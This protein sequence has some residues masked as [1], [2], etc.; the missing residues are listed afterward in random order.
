MTA[1]DVVQCLGEMCQ[2][3]AK[4]GEQVDSLLAGMGAM[5]F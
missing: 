5:V 1:Y 2:A 3:Q 4:S